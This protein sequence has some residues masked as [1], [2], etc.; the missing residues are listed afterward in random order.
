MTSRDRIVGSV[1]TGDR[2]VDDQLRK[3]A[4]AVTIDEP[5]ATSSGRRQAYDAAL[6]WMPCTSA[7]ITS[8][9]APSAR[10]RWAMS[11]ASPSIYYVTDSIFGSGSMTAL[12]TLA[13]RQ[14]A[15]VGSGVVTLPAKCLRFSCW[16]TQ[17]NWMGGTAAAIWGKKVSSAAGWVNQ[18]HF[19]FT[20]SAAGVPAFSLQTAAGL[21][22]IT[23]DYALQRGIPYYLEGTYDGATI[24]FNVNGLET[25][26]SVPDG[27]GVNWSNGPFYAFNFPDAAAPD[28]PFSGYLEECVIETMQA[29]NETVPRTRY[30]RALY[31]IGVT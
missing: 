1:F 7:D 10:Q 22:T 20:I 17:R 23:G 12:P 26:T 9:G 24:R 4:R 6:V 13:T 31:G 11:A 15:T 18:R 8:G 21:T 3:L 29:S 2:V 19:D 16:V 28:N 14:Y 30:L 25:G 5:V 27:T